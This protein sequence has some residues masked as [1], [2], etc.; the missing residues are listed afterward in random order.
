[1]STG[2]VPIPDPLRRQLSDAELAQCFYGAAR[3]EILQRLSLREQT[4]LAWITAVGVVVGFAVKNAPP[5]LM[6]LQIV[7]VLSLLFGVAVYRHH[8]LIDYLA[9]HI[10]Q[11]L[12]AHLRQSDDS[13][14]RHWDNSRTLKT[15]MTNFLTT[16]VLVYLALL[17]G[18]PILCLLYVFQKGGHAMF[19]DPLTILGSLSTFTVIVFGTKK[20]VSLRRNR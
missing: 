14:P 13:A 10:N 15:T 16:E 4:F 17:A 1:M 7:P 12:A 18:P 8:T 19:E 2:A 3:A 9:T 20:V 11:E 6:L 5:N